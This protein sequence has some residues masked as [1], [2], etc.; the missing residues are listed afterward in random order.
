MSGTPRIVQS[1][2]ELKLPNSVD[3]TGMTAYH[4]AFT[5]EDWL[6]AGNVKLTGNPR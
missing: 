2:R 3:P 6:S 4:Y 1:G 5:R